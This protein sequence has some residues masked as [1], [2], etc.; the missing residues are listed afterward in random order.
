MLRHAFVSREDDAP[1]V[2]GPGAAI[3]RLIDTPGLR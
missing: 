1:V 2:I 3:T